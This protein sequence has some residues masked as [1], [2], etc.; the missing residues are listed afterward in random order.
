MDLFEILKI[1]AAKLWWVPCLFLVMKAIKAIAVK[2]GNI[3]R[4]K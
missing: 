4:L 3:R 2:W 1:F